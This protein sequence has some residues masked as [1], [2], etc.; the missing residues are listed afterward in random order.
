MEYGRNL[1]ETDRDADVCSMSEDTKGLTEVLVNG[2]CG[3]RWRGQ[4]K[5]RWERLNLR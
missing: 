4:R 2:G 5:G 3:K 1:A